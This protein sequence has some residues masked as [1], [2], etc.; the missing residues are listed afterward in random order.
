[1]KLW[2]IV[3]EG[4]RRHERDLEV[5][6]EGG[7]IYLESDGEKVAADV[8]P[9][10]DGESY[11]LLVDGRSYEV[12]IEEDADGLRVTLGGKTFAAQVRSPLEKVLREVRHATPAESGWKLL[13]PMPG[14]VVS[15]KVA[16]G[17]SVSAGTPILI[18]EAM[19]MQNELAAEA[20]GVVE[21]VHV[22]PRQS[23][24]AG[25]TLVTVGPVK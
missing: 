18:M 20:A 24:E 7:R 22:A 11:S 10:P 21:Q 3:G 13:A 6:V 8:V 14:L 4:E 17:E 25:Q 1:M 16:P 12:S 23:V 9:L 5:Q 2:A 19:K 15:V